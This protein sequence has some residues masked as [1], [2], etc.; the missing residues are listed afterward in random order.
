[1]SR[2]QKYVEANY[3]KRAN[4]MEHREV[5]ELST[6]LNT[7]VTVR[8]FFIGTN[9]K[10]QKEYVA[11]I[12]DEKTSNFYFGSIGCVDTFKRFKQAGLKVDIQL[13]GLK[14]KFVGKT[15]KNGQ[16]YIAIDFNI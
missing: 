10:T 16:E 7:P 15:S 1:M 3:T 9:K 8:D 11:L 4:F 6:L 2:L 13:E 12:V 5:A 14:L